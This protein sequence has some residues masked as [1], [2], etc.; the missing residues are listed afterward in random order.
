M[1]PTSS[2]MCSGLSSLSSTWAF[3]LAFSSSA[4]DSHDV[5]VLLISRLADECE[6]GRS[7][8][9]QTHA[10]YPDE[11]L[12]SDTMHWA[13]GEEDMATSG[14]HTHQ[15]PDSTSSWL[16]GVNLLLK[17]STQSSTPQK[18]KRLKQHLTPLRTSVK[19]GLCHCPQ[20]SGNRLPLSAFTSALPLLCHLPGPAASFAILWLM[21]LH[22]NSC[23][24]AVGLH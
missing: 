10:H 5:P 17:M 8:W 2:P 4:Q 15:N 12:C 23:Y 7:Y 6:P 18:R 20:W 3:P 21:A 19:R 24:L 13:T 22:H 9:M 14:N 11:H 16:V 1:C